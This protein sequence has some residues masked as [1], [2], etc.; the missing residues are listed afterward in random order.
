MRDS[1]VALTQ[2]HGDTEKNQRSGS[3]CLYASVSKRGWIV[4]GRKSTKEE[5]QSYD[6][7]V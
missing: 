2:R 5:E 4:T 7:N 6:E 1:G 3:L